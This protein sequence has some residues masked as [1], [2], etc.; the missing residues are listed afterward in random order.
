MKTSILI[1]YLITS[2]SLFAS[3][4][5][6][7]LFV[8]G[9]KPKVE[10]ENKWFGGIHGG[11]VSVEYKGAYISF[12]PDGSFHVVSKKKKHSTFVLETEGAFVFDTTL[13]R[14]L[15]ITIPIDSIQQRSFDSI[16]AQRLD[17]VPYDYAFFGMRCA[18]AAYEML[19]SAGIFPKMGLKNMVKKYFY[20]K[21][22][23]KE[24]L[25]KAKRNKWT[26]V[27]RPGRKTR[28]WEKD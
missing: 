5:I 28:K 27:Y 12:L 16:A 20:P 1:F 10:S 9:S 24:L 4:S 17:S 2:Q 14:Y 7:V 21:L 18:S 3:D 11:H 23:R 26:I 6:R 19:S 13:S 15:I 25:R 8:Y 22:L